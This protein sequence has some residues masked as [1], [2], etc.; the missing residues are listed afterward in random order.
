MNAFVSWA[1]PLYNVIHLTN[2]RVFNSELICYYSD[3]RDP[4]YGQKLV[5]QTTS[6]LLGWSSVV[7]D[8]RDDSNYDARPGMP[9]LALLPNKQ[10]IFTYEVCGT[11]GCRVHYRLASNPL[12]VLTAPSYALKSN[13]GTLPVSSP[14]AVWSSSGGANGTIVVS[15]GS[16]SN[17]FVNHNL[18]AAEDWFEQ[19]TPQPSAYSRSLLVFRE[20]ENMIAIIGAGHLPPSSTNEVSLSVVKLA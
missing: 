16:Q 15:S 18:G 8:V 4:K 6:D 14:Y 17:I 5:H 11:D 13:V 9:S 20:N 3:Q 19:G 2:D 7:D 1:S 10:Y 12:D